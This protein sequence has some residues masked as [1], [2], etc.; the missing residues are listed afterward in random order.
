MPSLHLRDAVEQDGRGALDGR[1]DQ[2]AAP[3]FP[4]PALDDLG[5][6]AGFTVVDRRI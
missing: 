5:C 1:I 6:L 2:P 4:A 3:R